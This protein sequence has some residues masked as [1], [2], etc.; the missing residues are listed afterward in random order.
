LAATERSEL[1]VDASTLI[2]YLIP[3]LQMAIRTS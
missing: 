3:G 2:D 1:G